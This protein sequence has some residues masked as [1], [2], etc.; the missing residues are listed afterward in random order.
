[1]PEKLKPVG[2]VPH[3]DLLIGDAENL[4]ILVPEEGFKDTAATSQ[5]TLEA[6]RAY[7]VK[8]GRRCGL[9]ILVNNLLAQEPE[10]RRVYSEGASPELFFGIALVVN[11]PLAR[12]IGNLVMRL[13]KLEI[14]ITLVDSTEA[15][16][17]WLKTL[18]GSS[19]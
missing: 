7:A 13:T 4:L 19:Q 1:M 10:S 15:G 16:I 2:G 18:P 17:A 14:P 6:L 11:S 12:V 8:L 9:V 3:H 5:A